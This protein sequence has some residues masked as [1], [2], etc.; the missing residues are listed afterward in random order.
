M[1]GAE[2]FLGSNVDPVSCIFTFHG[3]FLLIVIAV[4]VSVYIHLFSKC[5]R[6][7]CSVQFRGRPRHRFVIRPFQGLQ[8]LVAVTVLVMVFATPTQAQNGEFMW[9]SAHLFIWTLLCLIILF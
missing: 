9:S 1:Y 5:H 8:P 6:L 2:L 3:I 4:F 7:T